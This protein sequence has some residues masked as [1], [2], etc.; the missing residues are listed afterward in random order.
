M[1]RAVGEIYRCM[2]EVEMAMAEAVICKH[3][4]EVEKGKVGVETCIRRV[5]GEAARVVA[6]TYRHKEERD[7]EKEGVGT[8]KCKEAAAKETV[9]EERRVSVVIIGKSRP[10]IAGNY[11]YSQRQSQCRPK[12]TPAGAAAQILHGRKAQSSSQKYLET[13]SIFLRQ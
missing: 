1:V 4:E 3:M 6:G 11:R 2:E 7:L 10:Y 5:V 9:E 12:T 8:G 13:S